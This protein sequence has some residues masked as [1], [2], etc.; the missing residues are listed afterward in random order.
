NMLRRIHA[1]TAN[2]LHG[3]PPLNE[4]SYDLIVAHR[5]AVGGRPHHHVS[6]VLGD[7]KTD[8]I[9]TFSYRHLSILDPDKLVDVAGVDPALLQS[10]I[11]QGAPAQHARA[12][13]YEGYRHSA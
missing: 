11:G 8:G 1:N 7:L 5:D 12:E 9:L 6:R 3:R 13:A 4:I 2:L 10:W